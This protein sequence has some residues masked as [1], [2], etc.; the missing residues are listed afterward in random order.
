MYDTFQTVGQ[1]TDNRPDNC[2]EYVNIDVEPSIKDEKS[3]KEAPVIPE[4]A[5]EHRHSVSVEDIIRKLMMYFEID[6]GVHGNGR[7]LQEKICTF[8]TKVC[9]CELWL[10]EEFSVK[11][12][13]S[14]GHGEF[15]QFLENYAGLLPQELCKYLTDDVIGKCPLEIG[16]TKFARAIGFKTV[17][18][19]DDGLEVLKLWRCENP[20]RASIAQMSKFYTLIWNEMASSKL[21]I[22]EEFHSKPS[23]F[24]PCASSLR[25][26]DVVSGTFLSPEEVYWHDSTSLVDQIKHIHPQ[27]SSTGVTHGPPLIKTL[28][29]FNPGLHD[30]FVDG[31]G[32]PET[33]PLRSYLQ[34][35]LHL[36]KVA[37]PSQ[38]ANAVFQVF[39]KWTD[40]LISGLSP[41]DIVYIRDSLKKIDCTVLPTVHDKWVSLH[42]SFGLVCWCDDK[43]LSKQFKHLDG[44]D[45]LY[46][47]QLTKDNEEILCTKMSNLIQTLGIPALSQVVTREAIYYGLQD[48][49]YEAGLV[50]SALPFVQRYLHTLH[51]DKYS[52]LKKSGFDILNC[53]QVV[54]VDELYYRNVIEVAGSES[55]KRVACS[56]LL[57]TSYTSAEVNEQNSS[58]PK[59]KAENWPPVDWKTAPGF[60]YARA[61]GFKTQPPALQ[62]CGA[63]PNMMDDDSEGIVGQIDNSAHISVD[64]SW[65]LEDYSATALA[66]NNDLLEHRSEHFN[67]TYFPTHVEFDPIN[68]GL[69]SHPPEL[70]SSSVGKREQLRYGT[71]NATQA[72]MTGR[73]G[74]H[75]AFKYFVEKAGESAVKWVNEHNETGLPYDIVLGENKE[76]VEVKATKSARK[77]WFEI[78]MNELQFAVEKGEAFSIAHVMLLD[79]NVAKVRVYNNLAK[80]C[81]LRR[82][83]LAV[84]IPVQ[85]KEFTIVS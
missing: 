58:K 54:V 63:L 66:D 77:D 43:K 17:V 47:G 3:T 50:N 71:P 14:L 28:C 10:V 62:P 70:G 1:L 42:P 44:I 82:L 38:A 85:P 46:F 19:L 20:F 45:F 52:E 65:S 41:E 25:H 35:L 27:C 9:S 64:T 74:E 2:P 59:R 11:E 75:V 36:S 84:L 80:L 48:S 55:K 5:V 67:D 37:L 76:Y 56:C 78:S 4:H 69:V 72:I 22:V 60:A 16:S 15:L 29:N 40:G 61:H 18:S 39:L 32:V 81:Q 57:K 33:P 83:K 8:L 51:P 73:L 6:Q 26:E 34:I 53:L 49:S 79:N 24:V 12:F 21:R 68:L 31:C 30:F 13:R 7:S 23:I